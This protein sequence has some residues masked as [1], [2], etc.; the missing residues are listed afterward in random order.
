MTTSPSSTY[1]LPLPERSEAL[2][3]ATWATLAPLYDALGSAHEEGTAW[4]DA[5][6][7]T[8]SRLDALVHEAAAFAYWDYSRDTTDA[9][10]EARYLRWAS[11]IGPELEAAHTRLAERALGLG[12]TRA[13]M[14]EVLED[15]RTDVQLFRDANKPR[16]AELEELGA[17]YDKVVGGLT[18]E[19]EGETVPATRVTEHL[20]A[21][22]RAVREAAFSKNLR[23]YADARAPLTGLYG[24][25]VPLRQAVA[26]EAG[27]VDFV[28]FR[29]EQLHRRDYGPTE[30]RRWADAVEAVVVPAVA[31]LRAY[32]RA[33]LGVD[34]L[35]PWDL[36]APLFASSPLRPYSGA[37][38]LITRGERVLAAVD[39]RIGDVL[40]E[41][42]RAGLLDLEN[43]AGKAPGGY[44]TTFDAIGLS[45]IFMNA[46]GIPDDVMTLLHEA[47]HAL[48]HR[49]AARLPLLWTRGTGMEAAELASMS[50]EL[51]AW[52][53][54]RLPVGF[55]APEDAARAEYEHLED[56]LSFF[57]HCATVE[58]FQQWVYG[59]GDDG[60]DADA[61]DR[62]WLALRE[63]FDR[64]V[65][66]SGLEPERTARW[67]KQGHI[68]QVPFYY[69]EYGLAQL[70]ALQ[71]WRRAQTDRAAAVSG[72]LA[73]LSLG[74]TASLRE[75]Y[76]AAGV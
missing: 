3:D 74:G 53:H 59:A 42:R 57:P 52:P 50:M 43:R 10:R 73:A 15:W 55:Y 1:L 47:G 22:D 71:I 34:V 76:A 46:V 23:A 75:I 51:L 11:E 62:A 6:I 7:A 14:R 17:E 13:D 36:S 49:L 58:L 63:R 9:E 25:M 16:L 41:M 19:W 66:W 69:I 21:P 12:I 37:D 56:I 44:C 5:W 20:H 31:R 33:R 2:R 29:Y 65:D 67:Y 38:D 8:W 70:G 61:Q 26:R 24:R 64:G 72:Y 48:H 54:M 28:A 35:R 18:V 4:A 27:R 32:R 30:A 39:A 68:F 45:G 60:A 40:P